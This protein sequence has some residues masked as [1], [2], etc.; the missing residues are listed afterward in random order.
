[1]TKSGDASSSNIDVNN[2]DIDDNNSDKHIYNNYGSMIKLITIIIIIMVMTVTQ[3]IL[4]IMIMTI[5]ILT[6][7]Q[8]L[9][10]HKHLSIFM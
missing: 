3:E 7:H 6:I 2:Y 4:P 9:L 5:L 8:N 10:E 1:M